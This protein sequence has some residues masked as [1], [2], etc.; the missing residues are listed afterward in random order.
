MN[1][2]EL[3]TSL[4][5]RMPQA[6]QSMVPLKNGALIPSVREYGERSANRGRLGLLFLSGAR[7]EIRNSAIRTEREH[8]KGKKNKYEH[9]LLHKRLT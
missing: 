1:G 4:K 2:A 9:S 6:E 3:L 8:Q 7:S 5:G